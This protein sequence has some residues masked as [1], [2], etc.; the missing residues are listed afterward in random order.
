MGDRVPEPR[1]PASGAPK[2]PLPIRLIIVIAV[3]VYAILFVML[4][5]ESVEVSFVLFSAEISLV[6]ALGLALALGLVAGYLL[7]TLR[8]RRGRAKTPPA[9]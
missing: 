1:P 3:A 8:E 7:D 6:V 2:K 9:S 4:N 5:S